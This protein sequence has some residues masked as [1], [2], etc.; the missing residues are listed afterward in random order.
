MYLPSMSVW[1]TQKPCKETAELMIERVQE[2][3]RIEKV[4][5][6]RRKAKR[7][8]RRKGEPVYLKECV[9][10]IWGLLLVQFYIWA[11]YVNR[12]DG[13]HNDKD[14]KQDSACNPIHSVRD[15]ERYHTEYVI[16]LCVCVFVWER[17][18][19]S[20]KER[21]GAL[22]SQ[23]HTHINISTATD[24]HKHINQ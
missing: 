13:Y 3:K 9:Y 10:R 24:R 14:S 12:S 18:R 20:E 22:N 17:N 21:E 4:Q 8:I 23:T 5:H 15:T 7:R 2:R 11:A 16:F 6:W 19:E 1:M